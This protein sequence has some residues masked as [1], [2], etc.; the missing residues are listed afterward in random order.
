MLLVMAVAFAGAGLSEVF[1]RRRLPVLSQPLERTALLLPLLPAVGFWLVDRSALDWGLVGRTP[2]LWFLVGGFYGMM[3]YMRGSIIC[4]LLA[5]L[6]T[7]MGLWLALTLGKI[8]FY[9]HPQLWLIPIAL[10]ALVAEFL[11]HERLTKTQSTIFR[12][13]ALSTIYIASTADMFIAGIGQNFWL[14]MVLMLLAVAGALLGVL[15]RIRSF[16]ILGVVFLVVD[17]ISLIRYA[18]VDLGQTWLWY[19]SMIALG[20]AIIAVFAFF[21]KRR[22]D[23]LAAMKKL[24]TWER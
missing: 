11:N 4:G 1:H 19:V 23:V 14:P 20:A 6:T 17:I 21:E 24:R 3:A 9:E 18:A 2:L 12:Y 5:V 7:N 10:C 8:S 15:L 22:N 16:L 13:L